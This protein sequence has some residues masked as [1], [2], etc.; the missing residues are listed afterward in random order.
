[1]PL[2]I[3]ISYRHDDSDGIALLLYDRLSDR[4]GKDSVFLDVKS[5]GLGT[6]W[7]RDIKT[8]GSRS[9]VVLALIG[10]R[11][12]PLLKE[13]ERGSAGTVD[14]VQMELELA[15]RHWGGQIIPVLVGGA[16]MPEP[17]NLPRSL[18]A[19]ASL[20]A[21]GLRNESFDHDLER[22]LAAMRTIEWGAPA[23]PQDG[24]DEAADSTKESYDSPDAEPATERDG[25]HSS[26][27][28][29]RPKRIANRSVIR[30]PDDVHCQSVVDYMVDS[31]TVVP[32]L[33]P[34]LRGAL[35]DSD[36]L[37]GHLAER[38]KLASRSTS[39]ARVA[40]E[41]A[42]LE[43]PSSLARE[44]S[45]A[46]HGVQE[47]TAMQLFLASFPARLAERSLP[48]RYQMIVSTGYDRG[49]EQAFEEAQEPYDLAVFI[50]GGADKGRFVHVPW[51]GEPVVIPQ[52]SVY[53]GFPID[54][55]DELERTVIVKVLGESNRETSGMARDRGLVITEDQYIDYL[56]TDQIGSV[57]PLQ[58]LNKLTSSH[59]LFIGY[60][61][62]DWSLRVFLRRIWH[63]GPLEDRSWAIEEG[64]DELE[65]DFWSAV[66]VEL[67][68]ST[69]DQYAERLEELVAATGRTGI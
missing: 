37:A 39:L 8:H 49:L 5:L 46:L 34:R 17:I 59:C 22:L 7:L 47:P 64:P 30:E 19:L 18:R 66:H 14:F 33:G 28:R 63:G 56:V 48:A 65:R 54:A 50:A 61:M 16:R 4:F 41:V 62:D 12:L 11:W 38:F 15:L 13:R 35:P 53:R 1:M 51:H 57:I 6:R 69:P 2:S 67:L 55:Y 68:A 29:E 52:P 20:Q 42:V 27:P 10:P 26:P 43:G 31:G 44:L 24:A 40:Q 45:E 9:G 58:I 60:R 32:V 23:T 21:V 36:A 3:F 25:A